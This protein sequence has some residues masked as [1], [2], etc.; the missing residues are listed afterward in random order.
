MTRSSPIFIEIGQ[1][2]RHSADCSRTSDV[3]EDVAPCICAMKNGV[4]IWLIFS[5]MSCARLNRETQCGVVDNNL[6]YVVTKRNSELFVL[7]RVPTA[8]LFEKD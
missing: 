4:F 6:L 3:A 5:A 1:D 2:A 7:G 8:A